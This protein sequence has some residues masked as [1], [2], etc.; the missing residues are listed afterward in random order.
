MT[1]DRGRCNQAILPWLPPAPCR[2]WGW[3]GSAGAQPLPAHALCG[4]ALPAQKEIS[5]ARTLHRAEAVSGFTLSW[6]DELPVLVL[7]VPAGSLGVF[8]LPSAA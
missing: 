4:T 6:A 1:N 2:D 5:P 3:W 7:P 8:S